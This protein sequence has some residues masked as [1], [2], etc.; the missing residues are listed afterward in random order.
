MLS[1]SKNEGKASSGTVEGVHSNSF[2]PKCSEFS[3][4]AVI[5]TTIASQNNQPGIDISPTRTTAPLQGM[6]S[7]GRKVCPNTDVSLNFKGLSN[8]S[9]SSSGCSVSGESTLPVF[10]C[11][12]CTMTYPSIETFSSHLCQNLDD[13]IQ[14]AS[15]TQ[16]NIMEKCCSVIENLLK[17]ID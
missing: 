15:A 9:N 4:V 7:K 16:V 17:L 10:C 13:F 2:P 3:N 6:L 1:H 8:F 12:F 11:R 14:E 5:Q